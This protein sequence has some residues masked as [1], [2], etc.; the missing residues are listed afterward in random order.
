MEN[1]AVQNHRLT[2]LCSAPNYAAAGMGPIV[3]PIGLALIKT[4]RRAIA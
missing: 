1:G 3:D 4:G 2:L